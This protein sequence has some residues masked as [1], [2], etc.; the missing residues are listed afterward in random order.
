MSTANCTYYGSEPSMLYG[1]AA[2]LINNGLEVTLCIP[3]I[4]NP[5][6]FDVDG[7]SAD[8]RLETHLGYQLQQARDPVVI[9]TDVSQMP[10]YLRNTLESNCDLIDYDEV[11][12]EM[13]VGANE[14]MLPDA[15]YDGE[16]VQE[17]NT[18]QN[19][20]CDHEYGS[21]LEFLRSVLGY[22]AP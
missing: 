9:Y 8:S 2:R 4:T 22:P 10:S 1:H 3:S 15:E 12:F 13:C 11:Q 19:N 14:V 21:S 17:I 6:A 7:G 20:L 18:H 16:Q 5:I